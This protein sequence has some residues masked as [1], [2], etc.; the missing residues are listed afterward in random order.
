MRS[1]RALALIAACWGALSLAVAVTELGREFETRIQSAPTAEAALPVIAEYLEKMADLDDFRVLQNYW[2]RADREACRA[3][4]LRLHQQQAQDP[5]Y[6][7][8][9][10]RT[11][12]DSLQQLR[13]AREVI[14]GSPQFY[15]GYRLFSTAYAQLLT[16]ADA[17]AAAQTDIRQ[18]LNS[19][20]ALL[21]QG[22]G[23]YPRDEYLHLAL[24]HYHN[25]QAQ[26]DEAESQLLGLLDPL[27]IEAN[28][29]QIRDFV[30]DTGR[31]R[32]FEVLYPRMLSGAIE[33]GDVDSADSL[34]IYQY[35]YLHLLSEL[36]EWDRMWAY[37]EAWPALKV[38]D[39]TLPLRIEMQLG[40]QDLQ[41]ALNLLEG[42]LA[43]EIL[44]F[45]EVEA[46][47]LYEPLRALPRW[48]EV[49]SLARKNW[50]QS[51]TQRKNAAL[52][53]KTA[54]PAPLWELPDQ[55]G[56]PVR[57]TD[58]RGQIVI[59]DFWASWCSPCLKTM[60][61]L[62]AW[63]KAHPDSGVRI[64]AIN[65]WETSPDQDFIRALMREKGY[66]MTL[67]FGDSDLPRAYGFT[68]IP[69]IVVID[70]QG[71]IAYEYS[72]HSPELGE[73]L[74]FWVGDLRG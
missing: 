42:G 48:T 56:D 52:A 71:R 72:G 9:W 66:A 74:D 70:P 54:K 2:M 40:R 4:F 15:W 16:D 38:M 7:Y 6:H 34:D 57:L 43:A 31:T 27:A 73:L 30:L 14:N 46:N 5:M 37:F 44:S 24:F 8:L 59:L 17:P 10:L 47:P 41:T 67:L 39:K 50:E 18:H 36:R 60:P 33:R 20:N 45:P 23:Y 3:H 69:Y 68:G 58:L 35:S 51:R 62:D 11:L 64:F 49:M 32:A 61:I 29:G 13:G 65:I 53:A 22:L 26:I 55:N 25:S 63:L 12:D 21:R 19:D 28:Y 1:S